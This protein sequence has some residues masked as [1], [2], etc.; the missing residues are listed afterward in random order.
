MNLKEAF[1]AQ[2]KIEDIFTTLE[3]YFRDV[4]NITSV[5][6]KHLRSKAVKGQE[7]EEL[8]VTNYTTKIYDTNKA[9]KFFL[10]LI[11][12]R[13]KLSAAIQAAKAKMDFDLDSAVD[14]NKKRHLVL[15]VLR[16]MSRLQSTNQLDKNAGKGYVFNNEGNQTSYNYDIEV[17]TTIDFDRNKVREQIQKL[18]AKADEISNKIDAALITTE[19]DY[20][21]PFDAHASLIEILNDASNATVNYANTSQKD[22]LSDGFGDDLDLDLNF[23][24]DD[25]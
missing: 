19:V 3:H 15:D 21:L 6:E 1:Q 17:V 12:E 20:T 25:F 14:V 18:Q 9:L 24:D 23:S 5:L 8:D 10:S 7:N 2:N 13:E 4:Q 16:R 22:N 11:G